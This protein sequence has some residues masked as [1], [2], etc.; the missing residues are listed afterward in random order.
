MTP[1]TQSLDYRLGLDKYQLDTQSHIAV[2]QSRCQ[3]CTTRPCLTVCPARVY[4]WVDDRVAVAWENCLEC[5]TCQVS[6]DTGGK[7]GLTWSY[8]RGGFGIVFRYG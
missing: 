1:N 7:G 8:P 4:T 5:G 2:D 3:T 6:C